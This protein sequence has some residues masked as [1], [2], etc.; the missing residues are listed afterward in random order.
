MM[1]LE[2]SDCRSWKRFLSFETCR[3]STRQVKTRKRSATCRGVA[4]G[5][6]NL[7]ILLHLLHLRGSIAR[8]SLQIFPLQA[9]L[10]RSPLRSAID[11]L[12]TCQT[13]ASTATAISPEATVIPRQS[14]FTS[15]PSGD[16]ESWYAT[17][18]PGVIPAWKNENGT[19]GPPTG[20]DVLIECINLSNIHLETGPRS[21]SCQDQASFP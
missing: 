13:H 1:T 6:A 10:S 15:L 7:A 2:T 12:C 21:S 20:S 3:L 16:R 4:G 5:S 8:L 17:G 11:C 9:D 19:D 14:L 18:E